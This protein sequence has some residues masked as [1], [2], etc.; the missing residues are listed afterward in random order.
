MSVLSQPCAQVHQFLC[1]IS[2]CTLVCEQSRPEVG[3]QNAYRAL[4]GQR[5]SHDIYETMPPL[6]N[7]HTARRNALRE[8]G[9]DFL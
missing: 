1:Y 2:S 5:D 9:F 8:R 6:P 7:R 3:I 4:L